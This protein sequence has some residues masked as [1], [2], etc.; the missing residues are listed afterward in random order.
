MPLSLIE[1]TDEPLGASAILGRT[2]SGAVGGGKSADIDSL[3]MLGRAGIIAEVETFGATLATL[4]STG[5]IVVE[6]VSGD[7]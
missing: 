5:E 3:S 6:S 2:D 7:S 4:G 1:L